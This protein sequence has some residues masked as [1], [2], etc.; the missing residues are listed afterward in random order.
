[1]DPVLNWVSVCSFFLQKATRKS[2]KPPP[3]ELDVTGLT[4]Q[5]LKEELLRH[6]LDVGPVVGE[7]EGFPE[8]ISRR[9]PSPADGGWGTKLSLFFILT[10]FSSLTLELSS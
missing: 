9:E 1:M 4:D 5:G 3:T 6:G 7:H 10:S 8:A 2:D